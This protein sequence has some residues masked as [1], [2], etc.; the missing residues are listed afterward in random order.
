MS[1]AA[2]KMAEAKH[3][4]VQMDETQDV[5]DVFQ[6][7]LSAFL[8]AFKSIYYYLQTDFAN[9][10][11]YQKWYKQKIKEYKG[12]VMEI[13]VHKRD[14][15]VHTQPVVTCGAVAWQATWDIT[16]GAENVGPLLEAG[17]LEELGLTPMRLQ[18]GPL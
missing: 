12:T 15:N 7:N 9:N 14:E 2:Q 6:Y 18:S 16:F 8:S 3:F 5:D 10:L 11:D 17:R 4:L 13:L 1:N